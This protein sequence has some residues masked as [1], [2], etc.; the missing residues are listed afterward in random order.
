MLVILTDGTTSEV[1][2]T[3][4]AEVQAIV[5]GYVEVVRIDGGRVALA[6]EDGGPL[7]LPPNPEATRRTGRPLVGTVVLAP[8]SVLK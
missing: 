3:T 4:F 1:P 5:G 2:Y 7:G 6:N 8:R